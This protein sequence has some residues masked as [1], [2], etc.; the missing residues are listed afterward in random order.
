MSGCS[1]NPPDTISHEKINDY[2][3]DCSTEANSGILTNYCFNKLD[4]TYYFYDKNLSNYYFVDE[5][6][7]KNLISDTYKKVIVNQV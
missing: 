7:F 3:F 5:L 4:F 1:I 2:K 6:K